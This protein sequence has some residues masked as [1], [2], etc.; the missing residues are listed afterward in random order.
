MFIGIKLIL[1]LI[2]PILKITGEIIRLNPKSPAMVM[3]G[4]NLN[5]TCQT[6]I[7]GIPFLQFIFLDNRGNNKTVT[8]VMSS[9]TCKTDVENTS[10]YCD[11]PSNTFVLT[12]RKPVHNQTI[13]CAATFNQ[14]VRSTNSTV[15]VQVP[16]S[17]VILSPSAVVEV[18]EKNENTFSCLAKR[19]RPMSNITWYRQNITVSETSS[20]IQSYDQPDGSLFDVRSNL[21]ILFQKDQNGSVI[22]CTAHNIGR[23]PP[24]KSEEAVISVIYAPS[25][26][27]EL[28][29]KSILPVDEG[30]MVTLQCSVD[31]SGNPPIKW[32]W[33]CGDDN[34]TDTASNT[35]T[36]ST[37]TF[38]ANRTYDKKK[39]NCRATSP[40][41]SL[42]NVSSQP[43][44]INVLYAPSSA[45]NLN[46]NTTFP[47]D[48]NQTIY[49]RCSLPTSGNPRILWSWVCGGNNLTNE[50]RNNDTETTLAFKA[51]RKHDNR[52]CQ[53]WATSPRLESFYNMSSKPETII[54]HYAPLYA[55]KMIANTLTFDEGQPVTLI[56]SVDT[57]GNP[58]ITWSWICGDVNLTSEANNTFLR[59]IL[60]FTANRKYNQRTCKCWAVS[61]KPSLSY[62]MSSQPRT[63]NVYFAVNITNVSFPEG[64]N[65]MT[66]GY[67]LRIRVEI[68]GN[69]SSTVSWKIRQSNELIKENTLVF[70]VIEFQLDHV[71]CL[72]TNDYILTASNRVGNMSL[73]H[74][75]LNVLCAPYLSID[76]DLEPVVV[77]D[78][79]QFGIK[80]NFIANPKPIVV[81]EKVERS[82][83]SIIQNGSQHVT[84]FNFVNG[85]VN[86]TTILQ[87]KNVTFFDVGAY[88]LYLE[89]GL[90]NS[91]SITEVIFKRRP[92]IPSNVSVTCSEPFKARVSWI[93]EF[94]G[95][96]NQSFL[97]AFSQSD[98]NS[99]KISP[100]LTSG[101]KGEKFVMISD[102]L[103]NK[104]HRFKVYAKNT[105][106]NVS[107]KSVSCKIIDS[108]G[109][110]SL[111]LIA[112]TVAGSLLVM[113]M[114]IVTTIFFFRRR[115]LAYNKARNSNVRLDSGFENEENDADDDGL[116]ENSLYVSAGPRDTEKPEVAV[117]AAVAKKVPRSDNNSNLYADVK[118]S[119]RKD[120]SKGT[121]SSEVKPKKGL[122]KKDEKAKHKK[123]KKSKNRPGETDVYENSEDIALSTNI[124]NVYSNAGQ[125]GLNKQEERGYKNKDGL[126]YIEVKFDGKQGQD[127]PVIHGEDEKT[128]YATVEFPMPS[129]LHKASGSEEL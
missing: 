80:Q 73:K 88:K 99:E 113:I 62:N 13:Y 4:Q 37:L 19:S 122:F 91:S 84:I 52:T 85:R 119:T 123:A 81:W 23:V 30:N 46:T 72:H 98:W 54:V 117:Y 5:F 58:H 121:V 14:T 112:S 65:N 108:E 114:I 71:T 70:N 97:I 45:P 24:R 109:E 44:V 17:E 34:L 48:E 21:T 1:L 96:G 47:V 95:G 101:E 128:D 102:L 2:F 125:K 92:D 93:A 116:K 75:S 63:I 60:T 83:G 36:L 38:A 40:R 67:P 51:N 104:E 74:F 18:N 68:F 126:L 56:C 32:S 82:E 10:I 115:G 61:P 59:S 22:Y 129:A 90:G 106:G 100:V 25:R 35:L 7:S 20:S 26:D 53:C 50:A 127:N 29:N 33:M 57:L 87:R 6:L 66:A 105:Y 89:N 27:P 31:T 55:P 49:L 77:G 39:C 94:D 42:Y 69:P 28:K 3:E 15:F 64:S 111:P 76:N 11:F 43:I 86:Y 9:Q 41:P 12:L 103:P 124:D 78:E 16:V 79:K 110:N 120:T 107:T 118:K 8:I